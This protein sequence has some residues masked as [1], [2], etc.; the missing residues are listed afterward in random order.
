MTRGYSYP[1]FHIYRFLNFPVSSCWQ[2]LTIYSLYVR[3]SIVV[4]VVVQQLYG[5]NMNVTRK[6]FFLL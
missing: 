3:N 5:K 1:V 6:D 2:S 4:I